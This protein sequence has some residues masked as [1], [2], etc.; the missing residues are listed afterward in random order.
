VTDSAYPP[1]D[2][3]S[4]NRDTSDANGTVTK[5]PDVNALLNNQTDMMAAASAAGEAVSRRIGDYASTKEKEAGDTVAAAAWAEG[6]PNRAMMQ[7]AGAALMSGL[8]GGNTIASAA[9]AGVASIAADKLNDLSGA[10]ADSGPTGNA[11]IDDALGNIVT[12][13][14]A[15]GAGA[16]VGRHA[17]AFS[18]YRVDRFNR[19][20]HPQEKKAIKDLSEGD[21]NKEHRLRAAGCALVHCSA[22]YA[23]NTA[24][25]K[26]YSALEKEGASNTVEQAQ[27]QSYGGTSFSGV[28]YGGMVRQTSGSSLFHYSA[29]DAQADNKAMRTA[30]ATQRPGSIDYLTVQAGAGVGGSLTLNLHNGNFYTGGSISASREKGAGIIF[31]MIPDNVGKT[32]VQKAKATDSLL[33]G[34]SVGGNLCLYGICGGLNHAVDG[35]TAVELGVGV[36][37]VTKAPNPNGNANLGY[38]D[39]V[40]TTPDIGNEKR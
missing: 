34:K 26:K 1:Q 7:A 4:L 2:I 3:A 9:G 15:T 22:E 32:D 38:S 13:V 21:A 27:L 31:G 35:Q 20:L 14:I 17:G 30:M 12:N 11:N 29:G 8:G 36:G 33:K 37:G 16:A 19:E 40:F 6:G 39:S 18:A 10:I 25:Y 24:D 5:T 28:S 23:P